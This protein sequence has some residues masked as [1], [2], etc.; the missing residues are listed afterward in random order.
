MCFYQHS[1][2]APREGAT[3]TAPLP[4]GSCHDVAEGR[5]CCSRL[6]AGCNPSVYDTSPKTGEEKGYFFFLDKC[7]FD[8]ACQSR[9]AR[10]DYR[11]AARDLSLQ[12]SSKGEEMCFCQHSL[13]APRE[14]AT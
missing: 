3:Y 2:I 4:E 9:P 8:S 14:G 1:L 6:N 7:A 13:I 10:R 5:E 11:H 12:A